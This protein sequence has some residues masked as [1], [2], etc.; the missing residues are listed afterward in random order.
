MKKGNFFCTVAHLLSERELFSCLQFSGFGVVLQTVTCVRACVCAVC[1][2]V[3]F[4]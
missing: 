1:V 2:Y 4:S 3:V